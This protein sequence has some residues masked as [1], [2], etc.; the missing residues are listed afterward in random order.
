M[1]F[2]TR[3]NSFSEKE[4]ESRSRSSKLI[5]SAMDTNNCILRTDQGIGLWK[6][7]P[8]IKYKTLERAQKFMERCIYKINSE[9][10]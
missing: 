8:T 9:H 7:I 4:L 3:M 2:D 10:L 5:K 1:A 6:Y